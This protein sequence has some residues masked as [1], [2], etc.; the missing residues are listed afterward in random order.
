MLIIMLITLFNLEVET[1][2]IQDFIKGRNVTYAAVFQYIKRNQTLFSGHIGK[3]NKIELDETAVQLLEE[4]YP[5][6]EPVQI[7]QDNSARDELLELHKKYTAAMEKITAL[8]EQNAQ[9][10]V[11]QSKQRFLEEE[12][13]EQAAEIQRLNGQLN[14]SWTHSEEAVKQL[15]L[16]E[17]RKGVKYRPLI[18][19]YEGM[20][21]EEL[22]E[23]LSDKN[24][25]N[26]EQI[27]KLEQEATEWKRDYTSMKKALEEEKKKSWWDKLRGR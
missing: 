15:L 22:F 25:R 10:L 6:P 1:L 12:N 2:K 14:E 8:T 3:T 7:I 17:L 26:L 11:V 16:S 9:L 24:T 19:K 20:A 18:E 4:K 21:L 13:M 23:V 5:F 27:E